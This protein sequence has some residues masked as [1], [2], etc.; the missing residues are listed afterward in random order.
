MG[1]DYLVEGAQLMCVNG[2]QMCFLNVSDGHGYMSGG[3]KKANCLDCKKDIHISN[4]GECKKN[5]ESHICKGYMEL[6]DKWE[7]T[8]ISINR[9]EMLNGAEAITMDSVL[10]CK[11]GGIIIPVTSGQG[12]SQK[13]DFQAFE[14]RFQKISQW[15][16]GRN[17][18]FQICREDPINMNTGNYIY[19]KEDL[20]IAG[21]DYL[22]FKIFYNAI[23]NDRGGALG[24]GWHHNYEINMQIST[25]SNQIVVRMWDGKEIL[26]HMIGKNNYIA[27]LG[28]RICLKKEANE[29][30]CHF[31]NGVRWF[32][33]FE[34]KLTSIKDRNNNVKSFQYTEEGLLSEVI[35]DNGGKF[36]Y[37]YNSEGNLICVSDNTGREVNLIYRYGKMIKFIDSLG[38]AYTYDYNE[39]GKLNKIIS[40][41]GIVFIQNQYD[42]VGRVIKQILADGSSVELAYDDYNNCTFLK[43]ENNNVISYES[44]ER[45]RNIRTIYQ[46]GEEIYG[47]N[48]SN[49]RT[50]YIDKLGNKT[51]YIYDYKGN[52]VEI[53][54]AL[55]YSSHMEYDR[56]GRLI[57]LKMADGSRKKIYYDENGNVIKKIDELGHE[58]IINY[59]SMG[60]PKEII[61]PDQSKTVFEYDERGNAIKITD[62][63]GGENVYNYNLLNKATSLIDAN[64]FE[65]KYYYDCAGKVIE[66]ENALGEKCKLKYD[67]NGRIMEMHNYNGGVEKLEYNEIGKLSIYADSLGNKIEFKYNKMGKISKRI[68][69][70]GSEEKYFYDDFGRLSKIEN[71]YGADICYKYDAVGNCINI[72]GPES[73]TVEMEYDALNRCVKI[74]KNNNRIVT[75]KYNNSGLVEEISDN[76]G[77]AF[78]YEYNALGKIIATEKRTGERMEYRYNEI[79]KIEE[80][81]N[82]YGKGMILKYFPGGLLKS[83][84]HSDGKKMIFRYDKNG[85]IIEKHDLYG[86]LLYYKYDCLNRL[87][88]IEVSNGTEINYTYLDSA[89]EVDIKEKSSINLRYLYN[90][91][92]K[93]RRV[94][95][96]EGN[97]TEYEYDIMGNLL[98]ISQSVDDAEIRNKD[99]CEN[100]KQKKTILI[101][102]ERDL[103]GRIISRTDSFGNKEKF[104]L[105]R[106]GKITKKINSEGNS[107]EYVYYDDGKIAEITYSDGKCVKYEYDCNGRLIKFVD[108]NG[109]NK[110][111]RDREGRILY[112]EDYRGKRVAYTYNEKGQRTSIIYP[113]GKEVKYEY[114]KNFKLMQLCF[115]EEQILYNYDENGRL[116]KKRYSNGIETEYKYGWNNKI[117]EL[118]HFD[119]EGTIEQY[120]FRYNE[121]GYRVEIEKKGKY[122]GNVGG[123]YQYI[124]DISGRLVEVVKDYKSIRK[125]Q[126]DIRG[127]RIGKIEEGI[128]T[129]YKY[130]TLNQLIEI[131][132][133][134]QHCQ[135]KYDKRGNLIE[136]IENETILYRF[137]FNMLNQLTEIYD[138]K[139]KKCSYT[140]NALGFRVSSW[141][142]NDEINSSEKE[143]NFYFDIERDSNNLL[144]IEGDGDSNYIWDDGIVGISSGMKSK[145]FLRDNLESPIYLTEK[146][147]R[148]TEKYT[149]DEFGNTKKS[150]K[151][152]FGFTGYIFE[153]IPGMYFAQSREYNSDLGRF[154][155]VDYYKGNI[156]A[157]VTLNEYVYCMNNPIM[158]VDRNGLIASDSDFHMS[159]IWDYAQEK[160]DEF[161]YSIHEKYMSF[162]D[163]FREKSFNA[164]CQ[165]NDYMRSIN[166]G[167]NETLQGFERYMDEGV[168]EIENAFNK[169]LENI[170]N[171]FNSGVGTIK[172]EANKI[173]ESAISEINSTLEAGKENVPIL[174]EKC[175]Q[176]LNANLYG[177]EEIITSSMKNEGDFWYR[178]SMLSTTIPDSE[179][180]GKYIVKTTVIKDGE[181]LASGYSLNLPSIDWGNG[182]SIGIPMSVGFSIGNNGLEISSS[183]GTDIGFFKEIERCS[184]SIGGEKILQ[185]DRSQGIGIADVLFGCGSRFPFAGNENIEVFLFN[186]IVADN[187]KIHN[188]IGGH[189]KTGFAYLTVSVLAA[190]LAVLSGNPDG[191]LELIRQAIEK[192]CGG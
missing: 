191:A 142:R 23:E 138:K 113:D 145:I 107:T 150:E 81:K 7:N 97:V 100:N 166:N 83:V 43:E 88:Q 106:S 121:S 76:E 1:K 105:N 139:G 151:Q 135:Y 89:L 80:I 68:N 8:N 159:D 11:R 165:F 176:F 110:I 90:N 136:I 52:L 69:P 98:S 10:I 5:M 48:T 141:E 95:D 171:A 184:M 128:L 170:S 29:Y 179:Y 130:N 53:K 101:E 71:T 182:F 37:K 96:G 122:L 144:R 75:Y 187:M 41:Q 73:E 155:S 55:G 167:M 9:P 131:E 66:I 186:E 103:L 67:E 25:N 156:Y 120:F 49:Q 2:S 115:D 173:Y 177:E 114:G 137:N 16:R 27:N 46:D 59:Q 93:L 4:F 123:K 74:V 172:E 60:M 92:G 86:K 22:F 146:N 30:V 143:K 87:I 79:G 3:R 85:N 32:F 57:Q 168:A 158:L 56:E 77:K 51:Q 108:W 104:E 78:F 19:E 149:Y 62:P 125:Y 157:P 190:G 42:S 20:Y 64:G 21:I 175:K 162:N 112:V 102:Y 44:D 99:I 6:V 132:S 188:E 161:T 140:Y 33:D 180:T 192:V 39:I 147:G 133:E 54:N 14:K 31:T 153:D 185:F 82:A 63:L 178:S 181:F 28:D 174:V 129:S 38:Y 18:D 40:P 134:H 169:G 118:K 84:L 117:S 148:I 72:L 35:G 127:N 50:F 15:I 61:F 119:G 34:G 70:N 24:K 94:I 116:I 17:P 65:T 164:N 163:G 26:F 160:I 189:V 12:Y 152:L 47:Y 36:F 13:V 154:M 124:Y 183:V 45:C 58:M 109:E 111:K 91:L 126:Y